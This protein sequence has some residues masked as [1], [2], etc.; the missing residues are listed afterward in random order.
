MN[1]RFFLKNI[2]L[3]LFDTEQESLLM[4]FHKDIN[5]VSFDNPPCVFSNKNA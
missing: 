4:V 2:S 5:S 1:L 3:H